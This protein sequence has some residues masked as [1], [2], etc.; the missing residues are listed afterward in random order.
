MYTLKQA[1]RLREKTQKEMAEMLHICRDNYRSL[2]RSP[3]R[4]TVDQA[5]QICSFLNLDIGEIF[6]DADSTLSRI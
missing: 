3:G 2:E 1:R 5:K 4:V 6:F